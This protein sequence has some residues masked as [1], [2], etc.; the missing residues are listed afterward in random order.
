MIYGSLDGVCA[1]ASVFRC[2]IFENMNF[3]VSL[4]F[5]KKNEMVMH[6]LMGVR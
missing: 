6:S 2:F 3:L 5:E 1:N 4:S